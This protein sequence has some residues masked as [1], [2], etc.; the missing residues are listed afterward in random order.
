MFN[1][2][3]IC[4]P[5]TEKYIHGIPIRFGRLILMIMASAQKIVLASHSEKKNFPTH[6]KIFGGHFWQFAFANPSGMHHFSSVNSQTPTSQPS[7][8]HMASE[9]QMPVSSNSIIK[10]WSMVFYATPVATT[11]LVWWDFTAKR[12]NNFAWRKSLTKSE[13]LGF[14]YLSK[15]GCLSKVRDRFDHCAAVVWRRTQNFIQ[16]P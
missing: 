10:R 4:E 1:P 9:S 15:V 14:W 7:E 2:V 11:L 5:T 8:H 12:W 6:F 16:T 3:K 13:N